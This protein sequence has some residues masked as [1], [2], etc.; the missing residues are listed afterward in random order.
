MACYNACNGRHQSSAETLL[1]TSYVL[2]DMDVNKSHA[3]QYYSMVLK[4][5][6]W[7]NGKARDQYEVVKRVVT[8]SKYGPATQNG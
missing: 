4:S 8:L 6:A 7:I 1:R 2:W 5:Q 3:E